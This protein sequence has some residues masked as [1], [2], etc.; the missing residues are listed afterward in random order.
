MAKYWFFLPITSISVISD[1]IVQRS[2]VH[3]GPGI[4]FLGRFIGFY[5]G[6]VHY[7]E[8]KYSLPISFSFFHLFWHR[9]NLGL[10]F[11]YLFVFLY[12]IFTIKQSNKKVQD[13]H[14][15][16]GLSFFINQIKKSHSF[17]CFSSFFCNF[18]LIFLTV[19]YP[20]PPKVFHV[21][22]LFCYL[23]VFYFILF[24]LFT[25]ENREN[26]A[27]GVVHK[28]FAIFPFVT[29]N[30]RGVFLI[31]D[32]GKDICV[33]SVSVSQSLNESPL[34]SGCPP[35]PRCVFHAGRRRPCGWGCSSPPFQWARPSVWVH[36]YLSAFSGGEWVPS[37]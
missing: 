15:D 25:S 1:Y 6:S 3:C 13:I 24:S 30:H 23:F 17:L 34:P 11:Y 4:F 21:F 32:R 2:M 22:F 29:R 28:R 5:W 9:A 20:V 37:L 36:R 16:C 26:L 7:T 27:F 8:L 18:F 19:F 10:Q 35:L 14:F 31:M 12:G 33:P